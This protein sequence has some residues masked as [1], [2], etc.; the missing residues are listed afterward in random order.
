MVLL[1]NEIE[2]KLLIKLT[3]VIF[4]MSHSKIDYLST[5]SGD[6]FLFMKRNNIKLRGIG[7]LS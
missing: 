1:V 5:E 7:N 4:T 6:L 3:D 2:L